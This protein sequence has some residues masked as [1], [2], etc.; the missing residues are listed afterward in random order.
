M[1]LVT[2]TM[3]RLLPKLGQ[4]LKEEYGLHKGVRDQVISLSQELESMH[5]ALHNVG[6]VPPAQLDEQVKLWA[7]DVREV[8]YDM[9]DIIDTFLVRVD[10]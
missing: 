5:A 4:L 3:G 2:G 7:R 8:S 10:G 6:E 9:E 1:E